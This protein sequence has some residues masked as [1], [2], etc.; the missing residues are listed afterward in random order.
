MYENAH[1]TSAF[2]DVLLALG[3]TA[4]GRYITAERLTTE[5]LWKSI[6]FEDSV[7]PEARRHLKEFLHGATL[8]EQQSFLRFV[9]SRSI[10]PREGSIVVQFAESAEQRLP[11]ART[12]FLQ[13]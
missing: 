13:L 3:G 4:F 1:L 11:Q 8:H 5:T 6:A 12:C 10:L 2:E 7:P 9:S